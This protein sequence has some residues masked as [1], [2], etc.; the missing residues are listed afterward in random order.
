MSSSIDR[1]K[2]IGTADAS[3]RIRRLQIGREDA[4]FERDWDE[5][6][7]RF[8]PSKRCFEIETSG[9]SESE[10]T[11]AESRELAGPDGKN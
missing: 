8:D 2:N 7:I 4:L 6:V 10:S 9:G 11:N 3:H 5:L 1:T